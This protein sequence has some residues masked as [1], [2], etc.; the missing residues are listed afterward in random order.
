MLPSPTGTWTTRSDCLARRPGSSGSID[1]TSVRILV[2]DTVYIYASNGSKV[3]KVSARG[4]T[5][6]AVVYGLACNFLYSFSV[7]AWYSSGE[8]S[9]LSGALSFLTAS[10]PGAIGLSLPGGSSAVW[11]AVLIVAA[12]AVAV[13][14]T[15]SHRSRRPPSRSI[16]SKPPGSG[17]R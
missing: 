1:P 11:L 12:V 4:A 7:Q 2:N 3:E 13:V 8:S 15:V 14:W 6:S 9:P 5:T 17:R 10:T 16:H